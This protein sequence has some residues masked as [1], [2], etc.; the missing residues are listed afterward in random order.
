MQALGGEELMSRTIL[1]PRTDSEPIR[2]TTED[3]L[4]RTIW[5]TTALCEAMKLLDDVRGGATL[6]TSQL[7]LIERIRA[8]M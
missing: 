8:G 5:L 4:D 1:P 6:D 2:A 3:L 7:E